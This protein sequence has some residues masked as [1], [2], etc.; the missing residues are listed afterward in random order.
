MVY[1]QITENVLTIFDGHAVSKLA[2]GKEL[3]RI[4]E[5]S[6]ASQVWRRCIFSLNM[7]WVFHSFLYELGI[8]RERTKDVDLDYPCDQPEWLYCILGLLVWPFTFKTK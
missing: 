3:R 6:P 8:E 4:R 5:S 2:Y 7:E 1:Y